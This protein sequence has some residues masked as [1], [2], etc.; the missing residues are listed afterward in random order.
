MND[1]RRKREPVFSLRAAVRNVFHYPAFAF[2]ILDGTPVS[3]RR[4]TDY[5]AGLIFLYYGFA[6]IK[7][8]IGN[9]AASN[10]FCV[11]I[12]IFEVKVIILREIVS[13]IR[14]IDREHISAVPFGES[15]Y[16]ILIGALIFPVATACSVKRKK[17]RIRFYKTSFV[18][19]SLALKVVRVG[20]NH[21]RVTLFDVILHYLTRNLAIPSFGSR[22]FNHPAFAFE[23][24]YLSV[25]ARGSEQPF[26]F[27]FIIDF[28][29]FGDDDFQRINVRVFGIDI[30]IS[31]RILV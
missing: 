6:F 25:V 9:V 27:V 22:I 30:N 28:N 23:I 5:P 7:Y 12:L 3:R 24:G 11:G 26:A 2:Y 19:V 10:G 16:E 4:I 18:R 13:R 20:Y 8:Y 15:V 21:S 17:S 1:L 14:Q 29:K 31:A